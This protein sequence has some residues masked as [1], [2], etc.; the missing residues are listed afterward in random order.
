MEKTAGGERWKRKDQGGGGKYRGLVG[1]GG[2]N[3]ILFTRFL[4][5]KGKS[6]IEKASE[7]VKKIA[8]KEVKKN[9]E[10]GGS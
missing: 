6:A 5:R 2:F 8:E 1:R 3:S 4:E 7:R 10:G 9:E